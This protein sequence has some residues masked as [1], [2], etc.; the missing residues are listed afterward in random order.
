MKLRT[1]VA[2]AA[3]VLIPVVTVAATPGLDGVEHS[4][5]DRL[6]EV[7]DLTDE[8]T[9]AIG[10]IV[11]ASESEGKAIREGLD[12]RL[13]ELR[14]AREAA[15]EREMKRLLREVDSLKEDAHSLRLSSVDQLR[16]ELT[17][18]QEVRFVEM[19]FERHDR[20]KRMQEGLRRR[21]IEGERR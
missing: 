7:L 2:A 15:D 11:E 18:T 17:L 1:M 4:R 6:A 20:M 8:Q 19:E 21:S 9:E 13:G 10:A 12:S 3:L 14:A 16:A 5:V